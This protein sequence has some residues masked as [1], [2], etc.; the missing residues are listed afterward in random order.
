MTIILYILTT[1]LFDTW[2]LLFFPT[3]PFLTHARAA[4]HP[5]MLSISI[6]VCSRLYDIYT[7]TDL[8]A[9]MP[10][11]LF[12]CRMLNIYIIFSSSISRVFFF[13]SSFSVSKSFRLS[14]LPIPMKIH[15][16]FGPPFL[17]FF[18]F[19]SFFSVEMTTCH[20]S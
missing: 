8:C 15:F 7:A 13:F 16:V 12:L 6:L 14:L 11:V 5:F 18:F 2:S 17:V 9:F 20:R 10:N 4:S 19:L 3:F 1:Y